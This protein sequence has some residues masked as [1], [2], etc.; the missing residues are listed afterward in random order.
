MMS[1]TIHERMPVWPGDPSVD[2]HRISKIEEGANANVSF[3][4]LGVHTGTHVDAPYHF[5][6]EGKYVDALLLDILIGPTMVVGIDSSI[7]EINESVVK[8]VHLKPGYPNSLRRP[9]IPFWLG[10]AEFQPAL[11]G[12]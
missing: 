10:H 7:I 11:C 9:E 2:L 6:M 3:L 4:V 12:S 5:L 1:V 8:A